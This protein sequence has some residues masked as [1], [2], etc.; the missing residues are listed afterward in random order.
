M[1]PYVG[2]IRIVSFKL[3]PRGWAFCDGRSLLI[4][5]HTA[6][7]SLIGT[8]YGGDGRTTFNLPDFRESVPLCQGQGAGLI[9]REMGE[10]GGS[11][12]VTLTAKQLGSHSHALM[13]TATPAD[14]TNPA[15]CLPSIPQSDDPRNPGN[16]YSSTAP[17]TFML[18][19]GLSLAGGNQPHN[20]MQP[21]LALNFIIALSGVFP[22]SA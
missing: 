20:N 18:A 10:R 15:N 3:A 12:Q 14:S 4:S 9:N 8:T 22:T 7:F 6:L 16:L 1:D 19:G 21:Y 11:S 2:E 17:D 5:Q 13:G